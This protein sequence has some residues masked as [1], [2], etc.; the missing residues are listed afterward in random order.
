M[1]AT[2]TYCALAAGLLALAATTPAMAQSTA[3][4]GPTKIKTKHKRGQE[5]APAATA[6]SV[7]AAPTPTDYSLPYAASITPDGLKQDLSVL[8]SDAYEGR[9]TGKKGQKMAADYLAKAFAADGLTGPVAGSDNPYLQHFDMTRMSLDAP[10]SVLKVGPKTYQGNKDFYAIVTDAFAVPVTLKPVFVG[11]GIKEEKYSDF[12]TAADYKGKDVVL[13]LGEPLNAKGQS[14]LGADGK[15]SPYAPADYA[16][17]VS[18]QGALAPLGA[19][20][21]TLIMPT[22]ASLA[23]V[24]QAFGQVLGIDQLSFVGKK[25]QDGPNFFF[26][27]P[28]LGAQILGTTPAG[29]AQYRKAVAK[30]GKP[31]A[32]SFK[33]AP[34]E[35]KAVLRNEPFTTENVLGY[36]EGS[37]KKDEVIVVSAHYDHLGIKY[38]EV[39]NGADDDGSGTVSVLAMARAFAQAKKDGHGPRR[40][41]LFLANTGEEEGALGSQYYTDHPV[42]PLANTVTDLNIDMVGRVDSLHQ[43]KGD[44]VYLVGDDRLSTELH[45]LS[46]ATNQ[47]YNPVALDYKYNDPNDPERVYYRSDHYNFAKHNVPVIF[48]YSGMHPQWHQATDDVALIDFPAMARR[49]QLIFHTAWAVANR[50]QRIM[51]DE[52]YRTTGFVPTPADL[53]RYAGT[54][55]S[56]QIPLKITFAKDGTTLKAQATGQPAF[57]I[58][59]VSQ[60]VFKFDQ[61]G[62][63]AA[64]DLAKPTFVLQQGGKEFTFTKE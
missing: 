23:A 64:F 22:A 10:A 20:S 34:V 47:Q 46:E 61:A 17:L 41:L 12:A 51:V 36:L 26:V 56:P 49:D 4:D 59:P 14:L 57:S 58:E 48:Y 32:S 54:Y 33:P 28:E 15:P 19:R 18:R 27:S 31:V 38:G 25:Q 29:L 6:T 37:D 5:T 30:S 43:G 7:A 16:G 13:L 21:F 40:S 9:E 35:A 3:P 11:Y 60:G 53:D 2:F 42:F 52:K 8:A 45:T 1:Q 39:Y 55:A 24:P 63:R 50:D 62:I 44:Y